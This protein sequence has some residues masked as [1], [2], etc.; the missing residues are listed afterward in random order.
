MQKYVIV[1]IHQED[2]FSD[3]D[4]KNK[5]LG[6]VCTARGE[7]IKTDGIDGYVHG[8][9]EFETSIDFGDKNEPDIRSNLFFYAVQVQTLEDN[10]AENGKIVA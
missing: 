8:T 3:L 9:L 5:L 7:L 10:T 2:G 6:Q 4:Y 1:D